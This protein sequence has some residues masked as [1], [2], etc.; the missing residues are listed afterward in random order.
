M[1]YFPEVLGTILLRYLD[2]NVCKGDFSK[3]VW[4]QLGTFNAHF[5]ENDLMIKKKESRDFAWMYM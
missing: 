3:T 1:T 4:L 5:K 2:K